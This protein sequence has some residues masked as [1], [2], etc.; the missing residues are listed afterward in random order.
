M[1]RREFIQEAKRRGLDKEEARKKFMAAEADGFFED[2]ADEIPS[3]VNLAT[4]E[5]RTPL[6][7]LEARQ[8]ED[9]GILQTLGRTGKGVLVGAA[10]TPVG[11]LALKGLDKVTG[12]QDAKMMREYQPESD[13]ERR[14]AGVSKIVQTIGPGVALGSLVPGGG[15]GSMAAGG[16]LGAAPE[17][18]ESVTEGKIGKAGLQLGGGALAGGVGGKVVQKGLPWLMKNISA[19]LSGVSREALETASTKGG[20]EAL[21]AAAG[22]QYEIGQKLV[23]AID[24]IDDFLPNAGAVDDA[25]ERMPPVKT[26]KLV[27]V[28]KEQIDDSAKLPETKSVNN[29]LRKLIKSIEKPEGKE[30][31]L[32]GPGGEKLAAPK[33]TEIPAKEFRKIRMEFDNII[34]DGFGKHSSKYI[35]ALKKGRH[36]MAQELRETAKESGVDEFVQA[37]DQY[38]DVLT[39]VD[40][41][42]R[43][44]GKTA[45][46]RADRAETF[47][48]TLFGKNKT[49]RRKALSEL[50]KVFGKDFLRE[51]KLTKLASEFGEEGVP[52]VMPRHMTGKSLLGLQAAGLTGLGLGGGALGASAGA[53]FLLASSPAAST[54]VIMPAARA[55]GKAGTK[56]F[57]PGMIGSGATSIGE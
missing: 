9:G 3:G 57:L 16:A 5:D 30:V 1:T 7:E 39:K 32:F 28:I 40:D 15:F 43:Y 38:H 4:E 34:G 20:R 29:K 21:K 13:A 51:A 31:T 23:D 19:A 50:E 47:V 27:S 35:S 18:A 41:V 14:A 45:K 8:S 12:G 42:N 55:L 10:K 44:L 56:K 2:E 46:G 25:L 26:D 22:K 49:Q 36:V 37:M 52:G 11:Q 53:P 6:H 48:S 17:A 33:V 54:R 24:N